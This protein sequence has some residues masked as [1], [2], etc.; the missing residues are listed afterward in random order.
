MTQEGRW[1]GP[2]GHGPSLTRRRLVGGKSPTRLSG[3]V[4]ASRDISQRES[5]DPMLARK[6]S[7]LAPQVPVPKTATGRKG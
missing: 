4:G 1:I 3:G 5:A 2:I 6:A 7:V